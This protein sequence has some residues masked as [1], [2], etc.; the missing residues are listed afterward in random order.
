MSTMEK[1]KLSQGGPTKCQSR[2]KLHQWK[3]TLH[4]AWSE[5]PERFVHGMPKPQPLPQEVWI[6]PPAAAS[7]PQPVH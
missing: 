7:T 6:N 1:E 4:K 2:T 3:R 5:H